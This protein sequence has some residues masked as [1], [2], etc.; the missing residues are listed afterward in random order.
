MQRHDVLTGECGDASAAPSLPDIKRDL[1]YCCQAFQVSHYSVVGRHLPALIVSAQHI[2]SGALSDVHMETHRILSRVYQLT[3]SFLHKYGETTRVAA[4]VAADRALSAAER[5][6]DAIA[7]GGASRRVAKSLLYQGEPEAAVSFALS[8]AGRLTADLNTRGPL[9]LSTLGM[10][11][12]SAA[13]SASG[14]EKSSEAVCG[15][16][17]A[18]DRAEETAQRQGADRNEDWT[19]FGP[20]NV[21]L[22]RCDISTRFEDGWSALELA[23]RIDQEALA[24]M[25]RERRAQHLIS[26][27]RAA[28]LARRKEQ[29]VRH[30]LEAERLAPEEVR[31]RPATR[32]LVKDILGVM[33]SASGDLRM[34]AQRCGLRA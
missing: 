4:A 14:Q 20:T 18:L 5:S 24:A 22:H 19:A 31:R 1:E 21:A 27:A 8:A 2:A 9:G 6:G 29:A 34:M 3:A 30:L 26:L 13:I 25:A 28:L 11:Y 10:L 12:L 17:D 15:A 32:D 23:E 16:Q 7:I 33:P